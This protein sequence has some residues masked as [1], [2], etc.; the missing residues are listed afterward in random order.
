MK[1]T[2][3]TAIVVTALLISLVATACLCPV[4]ADSTDSVMFDSGVTVFSPLNMTYHYSN[5]A[6]NLS[7]Y[8]A[9]IMGGLDPQISMNFSI[10]GLYNGS[11]PLRSNGEIHVVT[12]AVAT[13]NLP[14]LPDGSH[15]LTIYLFGLN[16]R[17]YEPKYLSYVNT[18]YFS[19]NNNPASSPAPT[20]SLT[21]SPSPA[22]TQSPAS[23]PSVT[24]TST[25]TPIIPEFSMWTNLLLLIILAL[26]A[27]L[28][29]YFKKR[30]G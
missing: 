3:L 29:V 30:K 25:S 27:G 18:I 1:T 6:L 10:D 4:G 13:V 24:V 2:W 9:G 16:Q 21:S 22:L 15:H 26:L 7:L 19:T 12:S 28:V 5:L 23:T 14:E 17:N 20:L 11:V 8:G